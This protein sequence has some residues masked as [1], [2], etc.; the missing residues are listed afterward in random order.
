MMG[1]IARIKKRLA[2]E[3]AEIEEEK[4]LRRED[5]KHRERSKTELH[6]I[7]GSVFQVAQDGVLIKRTNSPNTRSGEELVFVYTPSSEGKFAKSDDGV[8]IHVYFS[9]TFTYNTRD[10]RTNSIRSYSFNRADM[11][12][13][14]PR[15]LYVKDGV[16]HISSEITDEMHADL[17]SGDIVVIDLK[18]MRQRYY[19]SALKKEVE[20]NIEEKVNESAEAEDE[21]EEE[22]I[23]ST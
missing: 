18:T 2:E 15:Y 10:N 5:A 7:R 16:P 13:Q 8:N 4:R 14:G 20:D 22:E 12:P 1:P 23:L 19:N 6:N 21:E 17:E 3:A 9:G 11:Y